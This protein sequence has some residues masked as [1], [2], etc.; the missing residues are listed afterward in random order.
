[1]EFPALPAVTAVPIK[2]EHERAIHPNHSGPKYDQEHASVYKNLNRL[3]GEW[4]KAKQKVDVHINK[5]KSH[6]MCK[7]PAVDHIE[8]VIC[9]CDEL[10]KSLVAS[11]TTMSVKEKGVLSMAQLEEIKNNIEELWRHHK[12][13]CEYIKPLV[14]LASLPLS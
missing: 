2:T 7:E 10:Y 8:S 6:E 13:V 12:E 1:M 9:K 3:V 11:H 5:I 4:S 14:V